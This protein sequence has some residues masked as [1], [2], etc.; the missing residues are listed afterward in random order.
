MDKIIELNMIG[1]IEILLNEPPGFA[2]TCA[3]AGRSGAVAVAGGY[4]VRPLI[5]SAASVASAAP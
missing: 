2:A 4:A 3:G 1:F 5:T